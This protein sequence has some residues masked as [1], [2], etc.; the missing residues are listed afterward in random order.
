MKKLIEIDTNGDNHYKYRD[1]LELF[2]IIAPIIVAAID[3]NGEVY[4]REY[5]NFPEIREGLVNSGSLHCIY[6]HV[7]S[8]GGYTSA[9]DFKYLIIQGE[10]KDI[11]YIETLSEL[12]DELAVKYSINSWKHK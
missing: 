8:G 6:C 3:D 5:F 4:T 9:A 2:D 10:D 7:G 11:R 12:C 1:N